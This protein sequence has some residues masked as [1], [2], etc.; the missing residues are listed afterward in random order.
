MGSIDHARPKIAFIGLGAMGFAMSTHLVRNS[1]PV[2]G[3]DIYE[4]TLTRWQAACES[5]KASETPTASFKTTTSVTSAVKSAEVVLLMVATHHHVNSALFSDPEV[6]ASIP[7]NVPILLMSTVPPTYPGEVRKRLNSEFAR[8]DIP[9]IDAP[10]SGGVAR[11][12]NGTLTIMGSSDDMA[13]MQIPAVQETLRALSGDGAT[14]FPIPGDLGSGTSAKALNQV[15]CGIH[16]VGA[17]EIMA[18]AAV[19]GLNTTDFFAAV[20]APNQDATRLNKLGKQYGWTWMLTNRAPRML[21]WEAPIASAISIINKDVGIIVD[22]EDRLK[23]ELPL[24]NVAQAQLKRTMD[25][26][27]AAWDDAWITRYYL[28][29]T[30]KNEERQ[31]LVVQQGK[32][33]ALKSD[34]VSKTTDTVLK[35]HSIINFVSAYETVKFAEALDLLGPKQRE[36]WF[37]LIAGAAGGSTVFSE[38]VPLALQALSQGGRWQDGFAEYAKNVISQWDLPAIKS[39]VKTVIENGQGYQPVM[40]EKALSLFQEITQ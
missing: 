1:F 6:I 3:Y 28:D 36:M 12:S 19:A 35:A 14:F 23:I 10:V 25:D 11:S 31:A 33:A 20:D 17:S 13:N 2:T 32:A 18:L 26:G 22:E 39:L 16:I 34:Q 30:L 8:D 15:Q 27:L 37:T 24:L 38:V 4:P 7:R 21:N 29:S 9:L 40:L 5:I